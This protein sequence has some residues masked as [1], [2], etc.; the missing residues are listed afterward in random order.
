[1]GA[2]VRKGLVSR[3]PRRGDRREVQ[4][5][6]TPA[7][8]ALYDALLP[9]VA[10]INR[11]LLA[12]LSETEVQTL[13]ALLQRLRAQAEGIASRDEAQISRQKAPVR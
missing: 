10:A 4:L 12:V 5:T 11:E 13:D 6:L 1:V 2:L 8:R 9:R 7:G 3:T